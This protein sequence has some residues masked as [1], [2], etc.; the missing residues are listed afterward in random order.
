MCKISGILDLVDANKRP[1]ARQLLTE[2]N[3]MRQTLAKLRKE[4]NTKGVT[5]HFVN[6]SQEFDR[7]TPALKS[8]NT[9][10]A[11][12]TQLHKQLADLIPDATDGEGDELDEFIA[13]KPSR[14][15]RF[16]Y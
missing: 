4:I 5:E 11:R 8:Y 10:I 16:N 15:T 14:V 7:E 2:M 3:F 13:E 1:L 6:G 12:Y 9:T